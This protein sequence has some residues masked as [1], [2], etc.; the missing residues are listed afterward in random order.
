MNT[1]QIAQCTSFINSL[2]E[3]QGLTNTGFIKL[4]INGYNVYALCVCESI[5]KLHGLWLEY[6]FEWTL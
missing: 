1:F 4:Y 3:R 2:E 6:V 5:C